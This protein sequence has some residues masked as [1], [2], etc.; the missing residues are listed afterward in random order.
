M[1]KHVIFRRDTFFD[2]GAVQGARFRL[3]L[4]ST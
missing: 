2:D 3:S 1:N 4:R